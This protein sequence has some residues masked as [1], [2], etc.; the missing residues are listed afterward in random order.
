VRP[1]IKMLR[2]LQMKISRLFSVFQSGLFFCLM[3]PV[4][5]DSVEAQEL[6]RCETSTRQV[7][8]QDQPCGDGLKEQAVQLDE[9]I[10]SEQDL[11]GSRGNGWLWRAEN[12]RRVVYLTGS[13]HFGTEDM[14]PLPTSVMNAFNLS[15][16]LMVEADVRQS[17]TPEKIQELLMRGVLSDGTTLQ[18]RLESETWKKLQVTLLELNIPETVVLGQKIWLAALTL[19]SIGANEAGLDSRL[20]V[21]RHFLELATE[22]TMSVI[23]LEGL[24]DQI[25][26]LDSMPSAVQ[27]V[28]LEQVLD[29]V[30]DGGAKYHAIRDAWKSGQVDILEKL[31]AQEFSHESKAERLTELLL[32][33]RN[34]AMAQT[35][36]EQST[37]IGNYFVVVGAAHLVGEDS[38]PLM[39]AERGFYVEQMGAR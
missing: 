15:Q 35:I 6:F 27:T 29:G 26:M 11:P 38:L 17:G 3:F 39:L 36:D 13:I 16:V 25:E 37:D 31:V 28:L 30:R 8:Y 34:R 12:A 20:G 18:E 21:D 32:A 19:G 1:L 14:Y 4:L 2:G 9:S 10:V 22:S 5:S 23:E 7:H 24:S 33:K